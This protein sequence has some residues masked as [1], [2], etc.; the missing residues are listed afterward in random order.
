MDAERMLFLVDH[1]QA[2]AWLTRTWGLPPEFQET[3]A[4]HHKPVEGTLRDYRDM[5]ACACALAQAMGFRAAPLVE[6]EPAEALLERLPNAMSPGAGLDLG[7]LSTQ[8]RNEIS[9]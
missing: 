2:G 7:D 5:V 3:S 6:A 8:I 9:V 1:C 4:N